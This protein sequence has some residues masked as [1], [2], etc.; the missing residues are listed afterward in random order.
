MTKADLEK[1]I[2]ELEGYIEDLEEQIEGLEEQTEDLKEELFECKT[3]DTTSSES[4]IDEAEKS[5]KALMRAFYES[6][7]TKR[8]SA[9]IVKEIIKSGFGA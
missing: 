6:G 7:L 3:E 8:Q 5:V 2:E 1:R 4:R 9:E